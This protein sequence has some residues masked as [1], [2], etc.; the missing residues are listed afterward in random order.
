MYFS[1]PSSNTGKTFYEGLPHFQVFWQLNLNAQNWF[2]SKWAR[3]VQNAYIQGYIYASTSWDMT[4]SIPQVLIC[5][6]SS[7]TDLMEVGVLWQLSPD[8]S[9]TCDVVNSRSV[10]L[11]RCDFPVHS[12][13][14]SCFRVV[15][16]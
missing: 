1:V 15:G 5:I 16:S 11:G 7:A 14:T 2:Q 9:F 4:S 12:T 3:S 6:Y 13:V 8:S 10:R